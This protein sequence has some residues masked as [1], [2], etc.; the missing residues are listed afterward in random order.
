[1][2]EEI[3]KRINFIFSGIVLASLAGMSRSNG[4]SL[5]LDPLGTDVGKK[6]VDIENYK[7]YVHQSGDQGLPGDWSEAFHRALS[8]NDVILLKGDQT[9]W[10]SRSIVVPAG[11]TIIGKGNV[12]L[13]V[14]DINKHVL[15]IGGDGV[16]IH[17][18]GVTHGI[19]DKNQYSKFSDGKGIFDAR[20]NRNDIEINACRFKG[21]NKQAIANWGGGR[22]WIVRDCICENSGREF[23][24]SINGSDCQVLN[25]K[26]QRTGDDAIALA[27]NSDGNIIASNEIVMPGSWNLGGSGVRI[28]GAHNVVRDN[29]IS[30][31]TIFGIVL[32]ETS[33]EAA[34]P[35]DNVIEGN[36][37]IGLN[38][39]TA[40]CAGIGIKNAI[41]VVLNYNKID[42]S[43]SSAACPAIRIYGDK[44]ISR[45]LVDG[46]VAL[47]VREFVYKQNVDL[48][49]L[50]LSHNVVDRCKDFFLDAS[51]TNGL[52]HLSL[53]DNSVSNAS[54]SA[55]V[56]LGDAGLITMTVRGHISS[57]SSTPL[58][59]IGKNIV[60]EI[61]IQPG[62]YSSN[63][64][65]PAKRN[66]GVLRDSR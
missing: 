2:R 55:G 33:D 44:K 21:L 36:R 65:L 35:R 64:S 8:D 13:G 19:S 54:R 18:V 6:A 9:F 59:D 40:V 47:G 37:I 61:D 42:F 62:T 38:P 52:R 31:A 43:G 26:I 23:Y 34:R 15:I 46:V 56:V 63:F 45:I 12:W 49:E 53:I 50:T 57:N 5:I 29:L 58:F 14:R 39:S 32:A 20:V 24:F 4:A 66:Y 11:K 30:E 48:E 28:N 60:D 22:R 7:E 27:A 41:N 10:S 16:R 25:N 3:L 17:G 1:M 51:K